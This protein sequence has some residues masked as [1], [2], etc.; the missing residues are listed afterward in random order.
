MKKTAFALAFAALGLTQANAAVISFEAPL[1]LE[2]TEINQTLLLD[3]FDSSLG[4]LESVT[5]EV[6][7]RGVSDANIRNTAA[8]A[9]NFRFTS[10]LDPIFSGA[11]MD[12][13]SLELLQNTG[14]FVNIA[15]GATLDLG[16]VN[17]ADSR[18]LNV[19]ATAFAGYIGSDKLS[20]G[21]DS[22]VTNTQSGGGGNVVVTQS[23]QAGCGAKVTYT[24]TA[25]PPNPNPVP[26]PGSLALLGL[27]LVGL[28]ALRRK[29]A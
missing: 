10:V 4:T 18:S 6:F 23:T 12:T 21:C 8:N 13:I 20:F 27:G 16:K 14:G 22:F 28:G 17:I 26:E 25:T 29:K 24:Y 19:T 1:N 9:Q 5:V 3:K 2:T 15:S 7:G 11:L